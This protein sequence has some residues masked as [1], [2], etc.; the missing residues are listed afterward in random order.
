MKP[1]IT[2][3]FQ[4]VVMKEQP[5]NLAYGVYGASGNS[6]PDTEAI[7][8]GSSTTLVGPNNLTTGRGRTWRRP[9][10]APRSAL[11][12]T[13]RRSRSRP[14]P[15]RSTSTGALRIGGNV[16]LGRLLRRPDRRR[17]RSTAARSPAARSRRTWHPASRPD[18]TP[19]T[20][21][22]S[23]PRAATPA[24][25]SGAP[26]TAKFSQP[27]AGCKSRREHVHLEDPSGTPFRRPSAMTRRRTWRR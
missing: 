17:P 22:P 7:I 14:P 23:R 20:V 24:S 26:V 2:N 4:T 15:A 27:D 1:T 6:R 18:S 11:R 10:T 12:R 16:D 3:V 21:A 9:T 25:T 8:G 13:A 19:P 5:G